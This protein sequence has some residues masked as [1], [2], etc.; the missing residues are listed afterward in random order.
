MQATRHLA[1]WKR[2][3]LDQMI[4]VED[5]RAKGYDTRLAETLLATTQRTLA[6]GHRHRQLILQ[7]LATSR[8]SSDRRGSR[9][10]RRGCDGSAH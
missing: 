7:V 9:A 5:M 10:Q 4:V 6:E 3:V 8:Q 1:D 2:R